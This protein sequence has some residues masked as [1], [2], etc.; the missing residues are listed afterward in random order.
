MPLLCLMGVAGCVAEPTDRV[1]TTTVTLGL[2]SGP[3]VPEPPMTIYN[4]QAV[5]QTNGNDFWVITKSPLYAGELLAM[6]VDTKQQK[7]LGNALRVTAQWQPAFVWALE[8]AG[9]GY[10]RPPVGGVGPGP[11]PIFPTYFVAFA[12][13]VAQLD[14]HA[15]DVATEIESITQQNAI[16]K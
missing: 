12:L 13:E 9:A 16:M 11:R 8:N 1:E 2:Y 10:V 15:F 4:G 14:Q 3:L 5:P 7:I 6:R